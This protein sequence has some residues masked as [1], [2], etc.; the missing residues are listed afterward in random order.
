MGYA[1]RSHAV[2]AAGEK[3]ILPGGGILRPTICVDG[4]FAGTWSQAK[5]K[6]K[7]AVRLDPFAR[8]DERWGPALAAEAADIARFEG[9][10]K[11][12]ITGA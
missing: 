12:E 3:M 8:I 6:T 9:L 1:S 7:L 5:S 2:D 10:E 11:A 4:R